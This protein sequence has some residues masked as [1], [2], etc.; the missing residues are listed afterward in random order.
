MS[1]DPYL[2]SQSDDGSMA[3]G[4]DG[5]KVAKHPSIRLRWMMDDYMASSMDDG[6]NSSMNLEED[7]F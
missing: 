2:L 7:A 3:R 1:H 4:M 5:K 6:H